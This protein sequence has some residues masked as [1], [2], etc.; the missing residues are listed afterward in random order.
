MITSPRCRRHRGHGSWI[1][2]YA[3]GGHAFMKVA[4]LRFDTS[5]T[6]GKGPGWAKGM[7][8]EDWRSFRLRHRSGF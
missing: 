1:T 4:G 6:A 2:V 8:A 7:G 5:D 3:N